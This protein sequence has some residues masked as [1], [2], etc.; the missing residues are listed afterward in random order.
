MRWTTRSRADV[1]ALDPQVN[2][3]MVDRS[4]GAERQ[5]EFLAL[6]YNALLDAFG[7]PHVTA[8]QLQQLVDASPD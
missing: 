6:A 2:V 4:W 3:D 8:A 1:L 7:K 5:A